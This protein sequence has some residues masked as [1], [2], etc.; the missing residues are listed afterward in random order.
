MMITEIAALSI[1]N[2]PGTDLGVAEQ[3]VCLFKSTLMSSVIWETIWL[4]L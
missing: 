4:Q 1:N 3:V 2:P